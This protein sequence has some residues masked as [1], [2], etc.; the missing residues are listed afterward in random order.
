MNRTYITIGLA[1]A[2]FIGLGLVT[3]LI[4][5]AWTP[6]QAE[7]NITL[8]G[9]L[10][11]L[12]TASTIGYLTASFF[13]GQVMGRIGAGKMLIIGAGVM[14]LGLSGYVLAPA[15][16]LVVLS[17]LITGLGNGLIDGGLNSYIAEHHSARAMNW[18]HAFFGV[19]VTISPAIMTA[20]LADDLSWRVGYGLVAVFEVLLVVGFTLSAGWWKTSAAHRADGRQVSMLATLRRPI[21]W[22]GVLLLLLYA[23]LETTPGQWSFNLF[24]EARGVD[25][26][27]AGYLVSVYWGSFTIGRMIFGTLLKGFSSRVFIGCIVSALTGAIMLWWSPIPEIGYAGLILL[28]FSQA[29]IFPLLISTTPKMVGAQ[30]APNAIGFQVAGAGVGVALL[31]GIAGALA[32]NFGIGVIAPYIVICATL[33]LVLY[34]FGMARR[35]HV[36]NAEPVAVEG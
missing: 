18:L 6:M 3:G 27:L 14:A 25:A 33:F 24:T 7:F 30:H 23:G 26:A 20:I 9:T 12:L 31:P 29:P 2:S 32:D 22:L 17:G 1:Y 11:Q 4:N 34:V 16:E 15:W 28:G 5:V 8:D 36:A 19:G 21:V 35:A 10:L 13:S